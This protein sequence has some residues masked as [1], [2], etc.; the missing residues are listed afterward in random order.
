M[1]DCESCTARS[2]D[3]TEL[4]EVTKG[5]TVYIIPNSVSNVPERTKHSLA[6]N[7]YVFDA[8]VKSIPSDLALHSPQIV[9]IDQGRIV[10]VPRLGESMLA[11]AQRVLR[12]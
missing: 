8:P 1:P 6:G 11:F 2:F 9:C 10:E 4:A 5:N 3:V 12:R 7:W